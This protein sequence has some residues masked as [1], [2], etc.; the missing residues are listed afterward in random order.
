MVKAIRTMEM[1]AS[2]EGRYTVWETAVTP[3]NFMPR[4][5]DQITFLKNLGE[6]KEMVWNNRTMDDLEN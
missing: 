5:V 6:R 1:T 4:T 3:Q 2:D